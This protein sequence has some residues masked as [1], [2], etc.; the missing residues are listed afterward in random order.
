MKRSFNYTSRRRLELTEFSLSEY[1]K[2][3][4]REFVLDLHLDSSVHIDHE[5]IVYVEAYQRHSVERFNL[6][7]LFDF[8]KST[9]RIQTFPPESPIKYRLK[10]VDKETKQ[11]LAWRDGIDPRRFGKGGA[12]NKTILPVYPTDELGRRI[13]AL[14]WSDEC[15]PELHV[16]SR[17]NK[18]KDIASIVKSDPD[19]AALVF[20]EVFETILLRLGKEEFLKDREFAWTKFAEQFTNQ[21][22]PPYVEGDAE[23]E[24][25]LKAWTNQ[26]VQ[27]FCE[28][29]KYVERYK[30]FKRMES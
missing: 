30:D 23:S 29:G 2:P 17:V 18:A 22:C 19:F 14:K 11:L 10:I 16:N 13:W 5:G 4:H 24:E 28:R 26:V 9:V 1:E 3:A 6:G 8:K 20:P 25:E 15:S 27:T 7:R 12:E 21:E